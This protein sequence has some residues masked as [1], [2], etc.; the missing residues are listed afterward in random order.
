MGQ[1]DISQ[2]AL[3][4]YNDVFA[5]I[6]NGIIF[7]GKKTVKE[8]DLE[9]VSPVSAFGKD[10]KLHQQE[11]DVSKIWK[12]N[13]IRI[14][15]IGIENQ[16]K[17]DKYMPLRVFAYDGASYKRQLVDIGK[18]NR[19]KTKAADVKLYPVITLIIYFGEKPWNTSRSLLDSV[20]VKPELRAFVNDYRPNL[21]E[22]TG[23]S[24]DEIKLF[25]SDFRS[26]IDVIR[27]QID[28]DY[29]IENREIDHPQEFLYAASAFMN[30]PKVLE[31]YNYNEIEEG[32]PLTMKKFS[33]IMEEEGRIKGKTEGQM[34]LLANLI[35]DGTL[36]L[37]Q[38]AEKMCMTVTKFK[39]TAKKLGICL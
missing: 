37:K 32:E 19:N 16:T 33:E 9:D 11:R 1:K 25:K 4:S 5:D 3:E 36:T 26:L 28:P 27:K 35:K 18:A 29:E 6:M 31:A 39:A 24:R 38:A 8:Q 17:P 10:S 2:K 22:V 7:K 14:A 20:K 15:F 23:L 21:V 30:D 13:N 12:E 34:E